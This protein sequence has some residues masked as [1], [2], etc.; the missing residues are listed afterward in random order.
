MSSNNN[1]IRKFPP[2]SKYL[3]LELKYV[4]FSDMRTKT[5]SLVVI[6]YF[7]ECRHKNDVKKEEWKRNCENGKRPNEKIQMLYDNLFK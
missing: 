5:Q 2:F 4:Y 7:I 1:Y 6:H 3:D